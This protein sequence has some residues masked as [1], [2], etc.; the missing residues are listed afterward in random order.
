MGSGIIL[1]TLLGLA[2]FVGLAA[3]AGGGKQTKLPTAPELVLAMCSHLA[4]LGQTPP[5]AA[6]DVGEQA[7]AIEAMKLGAYDYIR[8]P[9]KL[10]EMKQQIKDI[11]NREAEKEEKACMDLK[12]CWF[13]GL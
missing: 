11:R 4:R 3:A 2:G 5:M 12:N 6:N 9:F 8:K 1:A 13:F 10:G 7:L